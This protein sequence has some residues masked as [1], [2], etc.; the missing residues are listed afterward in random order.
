MRYMITTSLA[1]LALMSTTTAYAATP[2]TVRFCTGAQGGNYEFS[3]L[4]IAR[5]M[6]G[7]PTQVAV[8]NTK[9][10]LE[11]LARLDSSDASGCDA[12]IVQSD[13]LAV[14]MKSNPRSSLSIERGRSMYQ[15]YVHLICNK[16]ADLGK[17][18]DLTNKTVV[19]VGAN[20]GGSAVTWESFTLADK[21]R[22]GVVPTRPVGGLRAAS[23]VQEGSEA[24]C[25]FQVIGLKA[26]AINEV[27]T[28]AATSDG[29]LVMVA[30]DDSDMPSVRDPKG[31]PMYSKA[32]I[33]GGTYPAMQH[34][35]F[36]SSVGT[37]AVDA[38][39]VT[40]TS[41]IDD[42]D[43]DYQNLLRGVNRAMPAILGRVGQ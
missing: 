20:G 28:L 4:E 38:V 21:T 24:A 25:M 29:R 6:A 31:K 33:P 36:S 35:T 9:G 37:I 26:P 18:T 16:S 34:G 10:S 1:A 8:V 13:A 11:N 5:Q 27:N 39:F 32:S 2:Q 30:A 43:A 7:A 14:Y 17:I 40:K 23:M 12:A 42:H 22:Y 41:W 19:L 15:E 3:G